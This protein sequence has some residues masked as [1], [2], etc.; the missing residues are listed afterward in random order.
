VGE[1]RADLAG[2]SVDGAGDVNGDGRPDTI[3]GA[4]LAD[5][6]GRADTGAAY[7]VFGGGPRG[8]VALSALGSRGFPILGAVSLPSRIRHR[9]ANPFTS[10]AAR[11][12]RARR[13]QHGR[14]KR[15]PTD[16]TSDS[17]IARPD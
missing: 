2:A 3:V 16:T 11:R 12:L 8:R 4:P 13:R 7:V 10:G 6:R 9:G 5:S 14:R 17:G 15:R 1:R